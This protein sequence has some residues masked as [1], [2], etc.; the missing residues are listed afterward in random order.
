LSPAAASRLPAHTK[1]TKT[2]V[3]ITFAMIPSPFMNRCW[4]G[5]DDGANRTIQLS[6]H[7]MSTQSN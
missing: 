2:K 5:L 1:T 7:N 4:I 6:A 3:R